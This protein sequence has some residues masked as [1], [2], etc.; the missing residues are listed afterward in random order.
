MAVN[1]MAP[2]CLTAGRFSFAAQT[3]T[4]IIATVIG[5]MITE[6][7][8]KPNSKAAEGLLMSFFH[9]CTVGSDIRPKS[10]RCCSSPTASSDSQCNRWGCLHS[11]DLSTVGWSLLSLIVSLSLC[12]IS[13]CET[14]R[15]RS[16]LGP[17]FLFLGLPLRFLGPCSN[18]LGPSFQTIHSLGCHKIQQHSGAAVPEFW[19][20]R[21]RL[22]LGWGR[23]ESPC[24][25][26]Q[27]Q[28][29]QRRSSPE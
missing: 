26:V 28:W 25:R 10:R 12:G 6:A 16:V 24:R 11:S 17:P 4:S 1:V 14:S 19:C 22:E 20:R 29:L 27:S 23:K 18:F 21:S 2:F 15:Y 8:A 13:C 7:P 9:G 3:S 5:L